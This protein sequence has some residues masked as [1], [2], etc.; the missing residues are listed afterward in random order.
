MAS[1][2]ALVLGTT[3]IH[4]VIDLDTFAIPLDVIFRGA[5]PAHLTPVAATLAD[6]HVDF[7]T[8]KVLLAIQS[9]L[10]R[11]A[12]KT[13]LIDACVGEHKSRPLRPEWN[14]RSGTRNLANL[15]TAGYAPDDVNIAVARNPARSRQPSPTSAVMFDGQ[16]VDS[17][18]AAEIRGL[19]VGI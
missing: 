14:E 18:V 15:A 16:I 5:T 7:A 1:N 19:H 8:G 13:I 2:A 4:R 6:R 3:T 11:F 9:F 10:M 17:V 12:G